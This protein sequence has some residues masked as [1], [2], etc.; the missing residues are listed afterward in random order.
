[1]ARNSKLM[2]TQEEERQF[3]PELLSIRAHELHI[4]YI[5]QLRWAALAIAAL[6]IIIGAVMICLGLTGVISFSVGASSAISAKLTNASPG[7]VFATS[8]LIL[9]LAVV[10]QSPVNFEVER[11]DGYGTRIT[12]GAPP[13]SFTRRVRRGLKSLL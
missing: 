6:L 1:M 11:P 5:Y 13:P 9:A 2:Q 8:G 12:Q 10:V 4:R 3:N 7:I